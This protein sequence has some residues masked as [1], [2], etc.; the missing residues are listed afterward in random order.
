LKKSPKLFIILA[1]HMESFIL[2]SEWDLIFLL[3]FVSQT[4][5]NNFE[6]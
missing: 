3:C 6:I 2:G 5:Q 1:S 4:I